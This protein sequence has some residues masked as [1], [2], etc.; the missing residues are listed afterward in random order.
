MFC[1]PCCVMLAGKA[2][3]VLLLVYA[4]LSLFIINGL[5]VYMVMYSIRV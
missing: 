1:W 2:L 5:Y 3:Y 4:G